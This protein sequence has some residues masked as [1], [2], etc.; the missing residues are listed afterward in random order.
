MSYIHVSDGTAVQVHVHYI[1]LLEM[2]R[3]TSIVRRVHVQSV[4]WIPGSLKKTTQL[5]MLV[6]VG[7]GHMHTHTHTHTSIKQTP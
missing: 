4:I 2:V 7:V 3:T 6:Y 1:Y 5:S